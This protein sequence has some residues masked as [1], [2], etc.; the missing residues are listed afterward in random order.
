VK[1]E[2][3]INQPRIA[4]LE[5]MKLVGLC[6][7][8]SQVSDETSILWREFGPRKA[9]IPNRASTDSLSMRVYPGHAHEIFDPVAR[10][11]KWAAVEVLDFGH[12]PNG[13]SQWTTRGG[14]YAIF[15][16]E[17]SATDLSTFEYIFGEWLP[18]GDFD[19]DHR[20]HFEILPADYDPFDPRAR[21]EI[22]VPVTMKMP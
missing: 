17:G 2:L 16:H 21:E 7:E 9:E 18:N 8:M 10:I 13:M 3:F 4:N 14:L 20:E 12:L 19:L 5:P 15:V 11:Q 22:C 1:P 6:R